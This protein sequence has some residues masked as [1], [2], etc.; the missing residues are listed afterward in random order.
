MAFKTGAYVLER[1][2]RYELITYGRGAAYEFVHLPTGASVFI[3]PG[4]DAAVFSADYES[5]MRG[6]NEPDELLDKL[7]IMYT[8]GMEV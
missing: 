6:P 7:W 1:T 3:Q 8:L 4:D 5:L 2:E